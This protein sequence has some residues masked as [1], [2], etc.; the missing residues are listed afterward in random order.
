MQVKSSIKRL[1]LRYPAIRDVLYRALGVLR[2]LSPSI[3]RS[4]RSIRAQGAADKFPIPPDHL[5]FLVAGGPDI[6]WFL[7]SGAA[8]ADSIRSSLLTVGKPLETLGSVLD[9]GCGCGRVLR[10]LLVTEGPRFHGC[11]YNPELIAWSRMAYP[12]AQFTTNDL[13]PPLSYGDR[14]FDLVYGLSVFTHLTEELHHHWMN[15][16]ARVI[17]PDGLALITTH[18]ESYLS[19][20]SAEERQRFRSGALVLHD[21]NCAGTNIC[22]A[23][24]PEEYVRGEMARVHGFDVLLHVPEGASGNPHQDLWLLQRKSS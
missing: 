19:Q 23:F 24:H 4:N 10:H 6:D 15:E 3:I 8:G 22:A 5:M 13:A 21:E 14:S 9:W 1:A 12:E 18:G 2:G 11:D 16:L 7:R 20:L 17:R